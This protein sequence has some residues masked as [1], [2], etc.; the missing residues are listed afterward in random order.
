M[1]KDKIFLFNFSKILGAAFIAQIIP[2]LISPAIS[3]I[4]SVEDIGVQG[5]VY[6][7]VGFCWIFS[8]LRYDN[9]IIIDRLINPI[10]NFITVKKITVITSI[11]LTVIIILFINQLSEYFN[12]NEPLVL[13][14]VPLI[15]YINA[16]YELLII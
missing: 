3:R 4:Y 6:S 10:R 14:M 15:V 5:V 8:T 7:I 9:V 12:L 13:L 2:V 16:S 1:I 11:F